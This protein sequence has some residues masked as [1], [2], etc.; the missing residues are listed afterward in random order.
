MNTYKMSIIHRFPFWIPHFPYAWIYVPVYVC[1]HIYIYK[2]IYI[3][4][5]YKDYNINDLFKRKDHLLK[6]EINVPSIFFLMPE[7]YVSIQSRVNSISCIIHSFTSPF[8][9]QS[10]W[11]IS[12]ILWHHALSGLPNISRS[13]ASPTYV[14]NALFCFSHRMPLQLSP[15]VSS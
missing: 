3:I 9:W 10:L 8:P 6:L 13:N 12:H 4:L 11:R 14:E 2:I 1:I 7:V 15:F 5:L